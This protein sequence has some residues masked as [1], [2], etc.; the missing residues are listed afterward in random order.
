MNIYNEKFKPKQASDPNAFFYGKVDVPNLTLEQIPILYKI[1]MNVVRTI[2]KQAQEG[3]HG[4]SKLKAWAGHVKKDT[5][6]KSLDT[7]LGIKIEDDLAD[8]KLLSAMDPEEAGYFTEKTKTAIHISSKR[9]YFSDD[10]IQNN[11]QK[12]LI[13]QKAKFLPSLIQSD[14]SFTENMENDD[15]EKAIKN[16]VKY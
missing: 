16:K 10:E 8:W 12:I 4:Y 15:Y 11:L 5:I 6:L 13:D 7:K 1:H 9:K 14:S 3:E 2:I